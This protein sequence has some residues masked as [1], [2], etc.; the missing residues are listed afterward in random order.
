MLKKRACL[1]AC[2]A[3]R[4]GARVHH[5]VMC[6]A[7]MVN[8]Y[9]ALPRAVKVQ[10]GADA[11]E[12]AG[13]PLSLFAPE[14]P[15]LLDEPDEPDEPDDPD[16]PDIP[17]ELLSLPRPAG[18]SHALKA[19]VITAA[20]KTIRSF[21]KTFCWFGGAPKSIKMSGFLKF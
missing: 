21:I 5:N 17:D 15:E 8:R 7:C 4:C 3:S 16:D 11:G 6:A 1:A 14:Y 9:G 19:S 13:E 12:F 20:D 2:A 10:R 18:L